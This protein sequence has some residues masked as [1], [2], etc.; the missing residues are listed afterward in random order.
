VANDPSAQVQS[1]VSRIGKR[2]ENPF[3]ALLLVAGVAF[4][5]T[6][7]AYVVMTVRQ[8]H[9]GQLAAHAGDGFHRLLDRYGAPALIVELVV[10]GLATLAAI[11]T[12]GSWSGK[13][14][15]ARAPDVPG[16][17]GGPSRPLAE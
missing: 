4:C 8:L 15:G 10:L 12:D 11:G 1:L 9:A 17:A 2:W 7:C 13:S 6:A 14:P 3:Y 5:L 16:P